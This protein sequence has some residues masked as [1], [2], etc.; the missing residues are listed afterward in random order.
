MIFPRDIGIIADDLTGACDVASCFTPV[1]GSVEV[2]VSDYSTWSFEELLQE[3]K[4]RGI[5]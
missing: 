1:T 3:C 2:L 5:L 4:R